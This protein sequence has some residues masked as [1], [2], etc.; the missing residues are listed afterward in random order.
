[1]WLLLGCYGLVGCLVALAFRGWLT[2]GLRED[3]G[4][5]AT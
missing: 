3:R 4:A 2:R 5:P 1:M